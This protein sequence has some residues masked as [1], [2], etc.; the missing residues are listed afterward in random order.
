MGFGGTYRLGK[1][2]YVSSIAYRGKKLVDYNIDAKNLSGFVFY[3]KNT[4]GF[5][6]HL[7]LN[8]SIYRFNFTG[9]FWSIG[10]AYKF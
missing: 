10:P 1:E 9:Q 2:Q 3:L 7:Q 4:V 5:G 8:L 6:E